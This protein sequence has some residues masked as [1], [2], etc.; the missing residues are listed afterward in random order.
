M[1]Q[2]MLAAGS[3]GGSADIAVFTIGLS[4]YGSTAEGIKVA[5]T[6]N[7]AKFTVPTS[8]SVNGTSAS[9][10]IT[11]IKGGTYH[12]T[13][14]IGKRGSNPTL[15]VTIAG[16]SITIPTSSTTGSVEGDV[17]VSANDTCTLSV[18][19]PSGAQIGVLSISLVG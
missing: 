6:N 7:S 14:S 18:Q 3:G 2:K 17:T 13:I 11:F 1:F 5:S 9:D 12:Y 4:I 15:S 10:T 8:S 19:M 16:T